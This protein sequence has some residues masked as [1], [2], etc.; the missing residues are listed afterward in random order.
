VLTVLFYG[1]YTL[2]MQRHKRPYASLSQDHATPSLFPFAF[3]SLPFALPPL[4]FSLPIFLRPQRGS[5]T[6]T[7]TRS[8]LGS[9]YDPLT[10]EEYEI[11]DDDDGAVVDFQRQGL[12]QGRKTGTPGQSGYGSVR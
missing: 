11:Q 2:H 5:G 1:T 9:E 12:L 3:P 4:P 7:Y 8:R 10:A 6:R